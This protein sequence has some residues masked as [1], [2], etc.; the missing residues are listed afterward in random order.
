MR[1]LSDSE[2]R[3]VVSL[4]ALVAHHRSNASDLVGDKMEINRA[5][6]ARTP[7]IVRGDV[8][9]IVENLLGIATKSE[10]SRMIN[11]WQ[12]E[13]NRLESLIAEIKNRDLVEDANWEFPEGGAAP[14]QL[15]DALREAKR[16]QQS[17]QDEL[18]I[19]LHW[20]SQ[21][22]DLGPVVNV[23]VN[24]DRARVLDGHLGRLLPLINI[25]EARLGR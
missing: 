15:E 1:K 19:R 9:A 7:F 23:Q 6:L 24:Q 11:E 16:L 17:M 3:A 4:K 10:L 2:E 13:A 25:L 21:G 5:S 18:E 20:A 12:A 22:L 8:G 14:S